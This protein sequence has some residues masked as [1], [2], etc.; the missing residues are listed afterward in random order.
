M[1][2]LVNHKVD[3]NELTRPISPT[4]SSPVFS[5]Q[6][7]IGNGSESSCCLS[8]ENLKH[9][10]SKLE[11]GQKVNNICDFISSWHEH[12]MSLLNRIDQVLE[13]KLP[14]NSIQT[15]L[16]GI[17]QGIKKKFEP[18]NELNERLNSNG[19]GD[20]FSKMATFLVKLPLRAVRN[21]VHMLYKVIEAILYTAVHPLK[22]LNNLAKLIIN[23]INEL[24]QPKN[25]AKLGV[26]IMAASV[27][28]AFITGNVV[29]VIGLIVGGAL[30]FAGLSIEL[31]KSAIE[32][33]K[34]SKLQSV[35]RKLSSQL[36]ELPEAAC[37]GLLVGLLV[38]FIAPPVPVN[39]G[40]LIVC[41]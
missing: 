19:D 3:S 40:Y 15:K 37:T 11:V 12:A 41:Y 6:R 25:W 13:E 7:R 24:T 18:L 32:A 14:N 39:K 2:N 33:E 16:D 9:T 5:I 29:S 23:L 26:G 22:S 35:G 4:K 17:A 10:V 20:W 31:L 27:G 38:G 30:T 34:G 28:Q 36:S 8:F 1:L 21:I